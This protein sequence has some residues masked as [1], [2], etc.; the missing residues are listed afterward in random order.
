MSDLATLEQRALAELHAS[1]DE[2]ALRAWNTK[3]FGK[4]GEVLLAIKKVGEVPPAERRNYGQQ[5][6]KMKETLSQAY[7]AALAQEKERTLQRDLTSNALD[8]TLPGRP[9]QR[10]QRHC[11]PCLRLPGR[12]Q[13]VDTD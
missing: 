13:A 8:I 11:C 9:V 5:A 1:G 6:N 10:P 2:A 3:Y 12:C 4:Q 7:D